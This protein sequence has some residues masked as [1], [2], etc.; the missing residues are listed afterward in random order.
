MPLSPQLCCEQTAQRKRARKSVAVWAERRRPLD[1]GYMD[2]RRLTCLAWRPFHSKNRRQGQIAAAETHFYF[3]FQFTCN[4]L[5]Q[6]N[7]FRALKRNRFHQMATM[8]PSETVPHFGAP[9]LLFFCAQHGNS[10]TEYTLKYTESQ[11]HYLGN[12]NRERGKWPI[13]CIAIKTHT[14]CGTH[15]KSLSAGCNCTVETKIFA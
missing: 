12:T 2:T 15:G 6:A 7:C 5:A 8:C 1:P 9:N 4:R 10:L 3:T 14:N 13:F 11:V